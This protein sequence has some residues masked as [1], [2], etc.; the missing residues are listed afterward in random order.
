MT[1]M[2]LTE[3]IELIDSFFT[4]KLPIGKHSHLKK[5]ETLELEKGVTFPPEFK[6]YIND[7]SPKER[8]CFSCV[9]NPVNI[10]AQD[11][12]S[13]LMLGYNYNPVLNK[14]IDGWD[15]SWFIF[16]D[17]G[18]DPIIVKLNEDTEKSVV[19]KAMHGV[20]EWSFHPI[21]DSICQFLLCSAAVHHALCGFD[22]EES[23]IDDENGFNLASEP[24][25]WLFPFIRLHAASYYEDWVSVFENS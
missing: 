9:G 16:A 2:N 18:S 6:E 24:A 5:S 8:F 23:I 21:A 17:E 19:Y 3:S 12:L 14:P 1:P 15:E 13:Y 25:K 22:I 10:Y 4:D 20:G 11:Q 7:F